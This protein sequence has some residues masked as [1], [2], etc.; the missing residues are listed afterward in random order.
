MIKHRDSDAYLHTDEILK[1]ITE[2]D[3]FKYYCP[4][5]KQLEKKFC[6][7]L[8]ED[9]SPSVSIT[10]WKNRLWYKDFGHP[11]HSFDC[12]SYICAKYACSFR[13]SLYLIDNDFSLNLSSFKTDGVY[14][15]GR[16]A[17][18]YASQPVLKSQVQIKIRQRQWGKEDKNFWSNFMI[19]KKT[20][21][22]FDVCPIDYC[23]INYTRF[24]CTLSYA[25]KIGSR[26]KIYSPYDKFKWISN[27]RSGNVQGWSQLPENGSYV[28]LTSSLKDVMCLYELGFSS[29]ALQSEMQMPKESFIKALQK[30]FKEIIVFYDN[31]FDNVN[32]PGQEMAKKICTLFNLRNI[33]IP[34]EFGV[35][36]ISDYIGKYK[37]LDDAKHLIEKQL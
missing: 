10:Q 26:Y 30:R 32:N 29:V 3:I 6:S 21:L 31:D 23:W 25:F 13:E 36:D 34:S 8:R 17:T 37:S 9:K 7:D 33:C 2:Y 22:K 15:M 24:P 12:F 28:V 18:S 1:K 11:E 19:G 4:N 20:L 14:S 5:F 35:K 16:K 27:T